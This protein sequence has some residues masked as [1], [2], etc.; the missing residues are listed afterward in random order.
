LGLSLT[1]GANG[2][3]QA[4]RRPFRRSID[5]HFCDP[6]FIIFGQEQRSVTRR[7]PFLIIFGQ[8]QRSVTRRWP[9]LIIFGQEQC[10][11]ARRW[12][13]LIISFFNSRP[14]GRC[15]HP[16]RRRLLLFS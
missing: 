9:F 2:H 13:F 3:R 12:P 7:W 1:G 10:S 4:C 8:E 15:S 14:S 16:A 6:F 11:V 5:V